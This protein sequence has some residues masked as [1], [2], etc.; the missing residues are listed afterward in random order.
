MNQYP[1]WKYLL[2]L[3][4]VVF[5]TLYALPNIF[6]EAPAIQ[7]SHVRGEPVSDDLVERATRLLDSSEIAVREVR[8]I[9][10]SAV[11]IVLADGDAQL[12]GSEILRADLAR[13]YG[14]ALNQAPETPVWLRG[15][16]GK[17]MVL[18]LDLRGG[19]HFLMEVDMNAAQEQQVER[20]VNDIRTLLRNQNVR[21]LSVSETGGNRIRVV[22]REQ[23]EQSEARS[24]IERELPELDV[25][26]DRQGEQFRLSISISEQTLEELREAALEQNITTL[27]N[28]VNELGVAEP[29][30]QRQGD[31][32]IVVQLPGVQDTVAAKE[33]L[34]TTATLEYR[35]VNDDVNHSEVH[36][37][38]RV[39]PGHRVYFEANGQ[40]IVL[41]NRLIV[42][43]DQLV[44]ATS[45]FDQQA[46]S[47]RVL[48]TLN[49]TGARRM[50]E[51]TTDNVGRRMG[52]VFVERRPVTE[53]VDGEPV[54]RT[55]V[56]EE[57]INAATIREP[58]GR[59]FQTTGI[60]NMSDASRLALLLRAGAL[61]APVEI[62]EER[63]VGPSLGKD[64]I[65]RGF[66]SVVVG[67]IA[68]LLFMAVYY[69][70]FGLV[71][72]VALFVNLVLIISVLSL[73]GATLTLPGIAGIVLTVGMAVDANVL[74]FDR[75]REELTKGNS[76]KAAIRSGYD[77]ALST[78]VDANV[79]TLI[80]AIVLFSFGTG[81]IK[82]FAITL[83][84][85]ILTSM[86]TALV[87]TRA[88]I[89]LIY[90]NRRKVAKLA[91]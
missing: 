32:R 56:T 26:S 28:R 40:P 64:N 8:R 71:A 59:R 15:I 83:S 37:S 13:E 27:R 63:T 38:G 19:V 35:L 70:V 76:P 73:L 47:P 65:E 42:S 4:V 57:V 89:Q 10:D 36:R 77:N 16:G 80:A 84:I 12:G 20:F 68:V 6:G 43:G 79:T 69:K 91:I 41:E 86:F 62:I 55:E 50:R 72:N 58:L 67:F 90:G 14:V 54:Q 33:I 75:I 87:G 7:I 82:G 81:P 45:G 22:L 53:M 30:I 18:G 21:Y 31:S 61:A 46:G 23:G 11:L 51:I 49:S 29:V 3:V 2:V 48:V 66:A 9:D 34:G 78:I 52:V 24:L 88:M 44:D 1:K 74:I 39:P 85:G 5:G 25:S 17:P 60:G